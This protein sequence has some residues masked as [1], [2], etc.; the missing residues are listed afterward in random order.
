MS[1]VYD[2]KV[3][4]RPMIESIKAGVLGGELHILNLENGGL[5]IAVNEEALFGRE[6]RGI[7]NGDIETRP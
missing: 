6:L 7:A 1:A 2:W 4:I 5:Y 3:C